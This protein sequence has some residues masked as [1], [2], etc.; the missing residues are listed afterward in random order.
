MGTHVDAP[1]CKRL[2]VVASP[3]IF[4]SL[5]ADVHDHNIPTRV[6]SD[7]ITMCLYIY[8]E[9]VRLCMDETSLRA[10]GNMTC[11][12]Y[13]QLVMLSTCGRPIL[14]PTNS[15]GCYCPI[16]MFDCKVYTPYRNPARRHEGKI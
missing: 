1:L 11:R 9:F 5:A 12:R 10:G 7:H 15:G 6:S 14:S 13:K 8:R 3:T 4:C 2:T 16:I